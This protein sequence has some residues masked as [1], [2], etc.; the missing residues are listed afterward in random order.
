MTPNLSLNDPAF[1]GI[2]GAETEVIYGT[3]TGNGDEVPLNGN[4]RIHKSLGFTL[5]DTLWAIEYEINHPVASGAFVIPLCV[6]AT[7]GV[8]AETGGANDA[9]GFYLNDNWNGFSR[10][11]TTFLARGGIHG[12]EGVPRYIT[13]FRESASVLQIN[14]YTDSARTTHD[15]STCSDTCSGNSGIM[16]IPIAS[17]IVDLAYIQSSTEQG[18]HGVTQ[19]FTVTDIKVWN[20]TNDTTGSIDFNGIATGWT[21]IGTTISIA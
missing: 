10:D 21:Q 11:G 15:S 13:M 19:V 1:V 17:T 3:I 9:L 4:Y 18:D 2:V 5:S 16:N 14:V 8:V 12:T 7:T 6:S 20:N